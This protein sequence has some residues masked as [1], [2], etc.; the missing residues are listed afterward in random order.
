MNDVKRLNLNNRLTYASFAVLFFFFLLAFF[1]TLL[2]VL[3]NFPTT[4]DRWPLFVSSWN[5]A[6]PLMFIIVFRVHT[7]REVHRIV[8]K[9]GPVIG[10]TPWVRFW[11][12]AAA[13]FGFVTIA[14]L[15][16]AVFGGLGQPIP[17]YVLLVSL[18]PV[19]SWLVLVASTIS[20]FLM[21]KKCTKATHPILIQARN[22]H[23]W[24]L[25]PSSLVFFVFTGL[26]SFVILLP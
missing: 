12:G 8:Q 3:P 17:P 1:G 16:W 6:G 11:F 14:A 25:I 5:L 21:Q 20:L 22:A 24:L 18:I 23:E 7:L 26:Y 9:Q 2:P 15:S 19:I 10:V 4:P 13:L